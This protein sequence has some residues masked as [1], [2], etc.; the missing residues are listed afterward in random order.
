MSEHDKIWPGVLHGWNGLSD[1][2][3]TLGLP[4]S[5]SPEAL[6]SLHRRHGLP[7]QGTG[8]QGSDV[9]FGP[10]EI[11]VW[12]RFLTGGISLDLWRAQME[13][14][15]AKGLRAKL[16]RKRPQSASEGVLDV[17]MAPLYVETGRH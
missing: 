8:K 7:V 4:R 5:T 12:V 3:S 16:A 15:A 10:E 6:R 14:D 11:E 9:Y 13:R 17:V 1:F 2:L